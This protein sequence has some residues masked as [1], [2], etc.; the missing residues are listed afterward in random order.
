[1]PETTTKKYMVEFLVPFPFPV[2]LQ[3]MIP[4]QRMAVHELFLAEKLLSYT[5][6]IDRKKLWAIFL[7][8]DLE[9]LTVHINTLPL[10]PYMTHEYT[11]LM[12]YETVQYI[13]SMSLN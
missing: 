7:A 3:M 10:S 4:Q 9:E 1:M 13:P 12:F 2:D 8:N 11:E 6:A 5:L